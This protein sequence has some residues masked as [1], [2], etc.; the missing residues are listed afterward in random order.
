MARHTP[1]VSDG[2]LH[3]REP[4][5]GPKIVVGSPSWIAWLTDPATRSFAFRSSSATYT[6]RKERRSR[7]GEYWAAY[8]RHSGRLRK[9]DLGKAEAL[10]LDRLNDAAAVLTRSDEATASS[11]RVMPGPGEPIPPTGRVPRRRTTKC[12][13]A[14]AGDHTEIRSL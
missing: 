10:T 11:P 4:S 6:A 5:G 7:G 8:R 14:R 3:V 12:G 13:S 2:V 9:A 1:Y